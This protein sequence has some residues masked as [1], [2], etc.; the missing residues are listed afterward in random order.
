MVF[1]KSKIV[2]LHPTTPIKKEGLFSQFIMLLMS[3]NEQM[4]NKEAAWTYHWT[5]TSVQDGVNR[6]WIDVSSWKPPKQTHTRFM[7]QRFF[8]N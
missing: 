8:K 3:P 4:V 2:L 1:L 6:D 7:K 5:F